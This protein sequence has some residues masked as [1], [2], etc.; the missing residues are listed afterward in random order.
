MSRSEAVDA[1]VIAMLDAFNVFVDT[2]VRALLQLRKDLARINATIEANARIDEAT[3]A[4][5][6][7]KPANDIAPGRVDDDI[8]DPPMR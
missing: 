6:S 1:R 3:N 5:D 2:V 8:Y 4:D 7:G